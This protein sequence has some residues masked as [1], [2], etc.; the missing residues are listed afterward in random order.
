MF[1]VGNKYNTADGLTA[2]ILGEVNNEGIVWL[3]GY[4]L[5]KESIILPERWIK[6]TGHTSWT[7]INEIRNL[8][9]PSVALEL[10]WA[11]ARALRAILHHHITGPDNG[12]RKHA[13]SINE[14][15]DKAGVTSTNLPY[16]ADKAARLYLEGARG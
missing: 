7:G 12:P 5:N 15:L 16:V 9:M 2:H 13:D 4:V 14:K 3:I 1:E 8:V 11:E 10:N 6:K